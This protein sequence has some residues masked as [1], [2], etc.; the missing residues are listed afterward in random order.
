MQ[1]A[2]IVLNVKVA[3]LQFWN[4]SMMVLERIKSLEFVKNQKHIFQQLVFPKAQNLEGKRKVVTQVLT[5]SVIVQI[6]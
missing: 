3:A 1:H 5:V 6:M 4:F 2:L